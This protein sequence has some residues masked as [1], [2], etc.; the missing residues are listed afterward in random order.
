M[1][2]ILNRSCD[3]VQFKKILFLVT[4]FLSLSVRWLGE[5]KI[6]LHSLH[7]SVPW[8]YMDLSTFIFLFSKFQLNESKDHVWYSSVFPSFSN[9]VKT[10]IHLF[11]CFNIKVTEYMLIESLR[12][13]IPNSHLL[14]S[15]IK[16]LE[17]SYISYFIS[18]VKIK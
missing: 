6:Q 9:V 8:P 1:L 5:S 15:N 11:M 3:S 13:K 12:H 10:E 4:C 2:K 14:N 17:I 16:L 7:V 18:F